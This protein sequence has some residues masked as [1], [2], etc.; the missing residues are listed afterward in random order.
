VCGCGE[1][2]R[3]VIEGRVRQEPGLPLIAELRAAT[4]HELAWDGAG[5]PF[6]RERTTLRRGQGT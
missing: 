4:G 6:W 1:E 3:Q 5:Y 2:C